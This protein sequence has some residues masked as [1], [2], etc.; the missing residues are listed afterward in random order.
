M[1]EVLLILIV[2][3]LVVLAKLQHDDSE[4]LRREITKLRSGFDEE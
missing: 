4:E 1:I 2:V 3:C